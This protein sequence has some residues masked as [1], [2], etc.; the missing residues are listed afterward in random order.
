MKNIVFLLL[1]LA[2]VLAF[3]GGD[4]PK[5]KEFVVGKV[6]DLPNGPIKKFLT[7]SHFNNPYGKTIA[8]QTAALGPF[9]PQ[10]DNVFWIPTIDMPI[11]EENWRF[12]S[13]LDDLPSSV[14]AMTVINQGKDYYLRMFLHPFSTDE[15]KIIAFAKKFGGFKFQFQGSTTASV[16]SCI[17]WKTT[18]PKPEKG[19]GKID[20]PTSGE[21]FIWPKVSIFKTDIDGSRLNPAKKMV[22]AYVVTRLMDSIQEKIKAKFAF[23]FAGEWV[24]GVPDGTDAG[25][26]V[27]E[28]LKP[29]TAKDGSYVEP[30]FSLLSPERLNE[31]T[32]GLANPEKYVRE[33]L[34]RP[35]LKSISYLLMEEGMLGEY[36]TQNLNFVIGKNGKPTGEILFHDADAFRTSVEL[37]ALNG[38]DLAA[39]RKIET[40]F[41]FL[42][43][44]VFHRPSGGEGG[45]YSLNGMV[46]YFT[47]KDELASPVG[48]VA[49]WCL[50]NPQWRAWCTR[51]KIQTMMLEVFAEEL[52]PY[53]DRTV[54]AAELKFFGEEAGKVGLIKIFEERLEVV[55]ASSKAVT[56]AAD[57]LLQ[58]ILFAEYQRL[59][60]Q[61]L[62]KRFK[63]DISL[64]TSRFI[65]NIQKDSAFISVVSNDE[66]NHVYGIAL[67]GTESDPAAVKFAD[68]VF[69]LSG[70]EIPLLE[71]EGNLPSDPTQRGLGGGNN[72]PRACGGMY[73][74]LKP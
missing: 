10:E 6:S 19:P 41:F 5:W 11:D 33:K 36:H 21:K 43:D 3:A 34:F 52:S 59:S 2:H 23:D 72:R 38:K 39:A 60:A 28:I 64:E 54:T 16:R 12:L 66:K 13:S 18:K 9:A 74:D 30:A 4:D 70:I 57:P 8:D 17:A 7:A 55:S 67:L 42:K 1:L 32:K 20:Y 69:R 31:I 14:K 45:E 53:L 62:A 58:K 46:S 22:R 65:L 47:E 37:R 29:F 51:A 68:K 48:Q 35:F 44:S 25:Y 26:V 49:A 24:V 63:G 56:R 50:K 40:P 27:R 71:S 61:G 15:P 73:R